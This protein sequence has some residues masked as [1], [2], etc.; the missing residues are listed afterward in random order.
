MMTLPARFDC[1]LA[2]IAESDKSPIGIAVSGGGDS[3]A[4]MH[5]AARSSLI[6]TSRFRT[7][8]VDHQL[9]AE[10]ADEARFVSDQARALGM[11]HAIL[12]WQTPR[13]SQSHARDA[14]H[15]L[16][17]DALKSEGARILLTG[18][19]RSDNIESFLMRARA[20]S[21]WYGLAGM[22]TLTS[23]PVWPE[24][25]GTFLARP[26][27]DAGRSEIRTW[28]E[29]IGAGWC[30]DPSNDNDKYERV[31][32]RKMLSE[33]PAFERRIS[34]IQDRLRCL[35]RVRDHQ[36]AAHLLAAKDLGDGLELPFPME[37][38]AET[39]AQILSICAMVVA[40][41]D[42]SARTSRCINAARQLM[43]ATATSSSVTLTLG[44]T[45]IRKSGQMLRF[46]RES[47]RPDSST[48]PQIGLRMRHICAGLTGALPA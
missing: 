27:L 10:A 33:A 7:F 19:T 41:T 20:G 34:K 15:R 3:L 24:G 32:V 11:S 18:H 1:A 16:L 9:R 35:R 45:I 25:S 22:G 17:A 12:T 8:T 42:R 46:Q 13:R 38:H 14:R 30:E 26:L 37:V 5:L 43:P 36:L 4:L 48:A 47:N 39:L 29:S 6:E 23:S 44:G 28:L 21:G 31:R 40:G 2:S